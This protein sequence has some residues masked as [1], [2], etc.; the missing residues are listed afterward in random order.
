LSKYFDFFPPFY[1]IENK[2]SDL[3]L[4]FQITHTM[5]KELPSTIRSADWGAFCF[6][7]LV[8]FQQMGGSKQT[9]TQ[10]TQTNNQQPQQQSSP[11]TQTQQSHQHRSTLVKSI[12]FIDNNGN[13]MTHHSF[14]LTGIDGTKLYGFCLVKLHVI[15]HEANPTYRRYSIFYSI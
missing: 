14:I 8:R 11:Q 1:L 10:Q 9:S 5:P 3:V 12:S 4:P 13:Q 15:A 2:V 6:P 7:Q